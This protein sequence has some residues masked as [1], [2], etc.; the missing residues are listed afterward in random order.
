MSTF[1][2]ATQHSTRAEHLINLDLVKSM[3]RNGEYTIVSFIDGLD[4]WVEES[5]ETIA[6]LK[7]VQWEDHVVRR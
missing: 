1:K 2:R 5:P 6:Q 4:L 7:S 3:K